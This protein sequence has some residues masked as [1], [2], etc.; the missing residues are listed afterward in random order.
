[1]RK[2]VA[3]S[4]GILFSL[5]VLILLGLKVGFLLSKALQ[6]PEARVKTA[7]KEKDQY[8]RE[9]FTSAGLPYP[10]EK[11]TILIFKREKILEVW[12][13]SPGEGKFKR[14][15]SYRVCATSGM[16][17][18]KRR[19]GDLQIPEGVYYINRFN[20]R[21]HFYLS[22]GLNYPN[23]S[24]LIRGNKQKPGGDIFIHGNCVTIGCIPITDDKIKEVYWLALQARRNGQQKIP[25]L[26]FP[27][28]MTNE[29]MEFLKTLARNRE[30]W[31]RYKRRIGDAHPQ[32]PEQLISFWEELK[33]IYDYF[34]SQGKVPDINIGPK[35]EYIIER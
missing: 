19:E 25:V 24:D 22:L 15:K 32:S 11:L 21:S 29:N 20:P 14:A 3:V 1:M 9:I 4:P 26:I 7:K 34:Y 12:G 6:N 30:Y 33:G 10:P 31:K 18:P 23:A 8:L 16:L 2:W 13:F 27:C 35:G 5:M 28:K 17:G